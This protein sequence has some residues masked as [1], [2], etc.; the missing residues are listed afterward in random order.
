MVL[1]IKDWGFEDIE[2]AYTDRGL[3]ISC[4]RLWKKYTTDDG[5]NREQYYNE[6]S[7][8]TA[9]LTPYQMA[10]LAEHTEK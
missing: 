2:A 10:R 8:I 4:H 5:L 7:K 9:L 3:E 6:L 1:K